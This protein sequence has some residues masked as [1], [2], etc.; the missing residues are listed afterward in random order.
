VNG[1]FDVRCYTPGA[2][3]SF[4]KDVLPIFEQSCSLSSSCHGNPKSPMTGDG[5][6]PY[7]GEVDPTE[8][9]PSDVPKILSLIVSQPSPSATGENIVEPGKPEKS[10]LM[11]KMDGDVDCGVVKCTFDDCGK[12]MPEGVKPLP[13][14]TRDTIRDWIQ[15]GALDN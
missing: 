3:R 9:A 7:L 11:Q 4:R 14:E 2:T 8:M 12:G 10:Y 13:Q 15:Q 5:Y 1:C 6:Q